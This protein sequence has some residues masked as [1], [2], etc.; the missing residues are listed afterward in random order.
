[1]TPEVRTCRSLEE[2][3]DA[4]NAIGHYFGH[5]NA[6]EDAR[7]AGGAAVCGGARV[8]GGRRGRW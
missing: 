1:M 3:R 7:G 8:G 4:M 6:L 2:L 5:E